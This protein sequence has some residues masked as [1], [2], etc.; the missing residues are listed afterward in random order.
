MLAS[1]N[2]L[3]DFVSP[4]ESIRNHRKWMAENTP[5]PDTLD[6]EEIMLRACQIIDLRLQEPE[7]ERILVAAGS[8]VPEVSAYLDWAATLDCDT[9]M[10]RKRDALRGMADYLDRTDPTVTRRAASG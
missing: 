8:K 1:A 9:L 5:S 7:A 4:F 6:D 10:R 2:I 3:A